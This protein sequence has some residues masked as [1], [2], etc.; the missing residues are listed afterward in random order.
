MKILNWLTLDY[1][2]A[3]G[4]QLEQFFNSDESCLIGQNDCKACI[5][6]TSGN[7][8]KYLLF[9]DILHVQSIFTQQQVIHYNVIYKIL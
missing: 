5:N 9:R 4:L 2:A 6:K 7:F 1:L 8:E 3:K